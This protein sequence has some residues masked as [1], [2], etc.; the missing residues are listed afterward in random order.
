M[1][2]SPDEKLL[3]YTDNSGTIF[4]NFVQK[5]EIVNEIKTLQV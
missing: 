5:W 4:M 1:V 2:V 3:A